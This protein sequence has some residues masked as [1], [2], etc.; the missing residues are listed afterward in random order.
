MY[1]PKNIKSRILYP[2]DRPYASWVYTGL[3]LEEMTPDD[4][5]TKIGVKVGLIGP[6]AF[7]ELAQG[8]V[9]VGGHTEIGERWDTQIQQEFGV[10]L[11]LERQWNFWAAEW[12]NERMVDVSF[13]MKGRFGNI[14]I[15]A[16][17]ETTLQVGWFRAPYWQE[18]YKHGE[19]LSEI[20]FFPICGSN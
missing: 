3:F 15:D 5:F 1:T 20:Y 8:A 13:L 14:H 4:R 6:H 11:H 2:H 18:I 10:L 16:T 12:K 9:H 7:G 17:A 19:A